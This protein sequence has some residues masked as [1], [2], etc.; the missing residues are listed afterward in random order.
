MTAR[1]HAVFQACTVVSGASQYFEGGSTEDHA[2]SDSWAAS[3]W[4]TIITLNSK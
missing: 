2:G 4:F 1:G 3:G